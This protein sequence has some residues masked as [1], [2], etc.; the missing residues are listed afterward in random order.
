MANGL[1]VNAPGAN[2]I[3]MVKQAH[4]TA[5]AMFNRTSEAM[6][7]LG[8][9]SAKLG[10][11][12]KLGDVVTPEEVLKAAG[13][14]VAG[15]TFTPHEAAVTLADMPDN[16]VALGG[17]VQQHLA[18]TQELGQKLGQMHALARHELGASGM[19]LLAMHAG[20]EVQA[21]QPPGGAGT[22][23]SSPG[24]SVNPLSMELPHAG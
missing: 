14:L 8:T 9:I 23:G 10:D 19:R 4:D 18:N 1:G 12:A 5:R 3:D 7:H 2:P 11:L 13:E 17:W 15:G 22:P 6:K 21:G 16:G 20:L 24:G